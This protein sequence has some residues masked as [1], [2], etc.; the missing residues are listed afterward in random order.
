MAPVWVWILLGD[1]M[2]SQ[3]IIGGALVLGAV[4]MLTL[5]MRRKPPHPKPNL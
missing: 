5:G 3:E 4:M 2:E 1:A